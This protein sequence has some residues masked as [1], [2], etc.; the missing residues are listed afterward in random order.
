MTDR[1]QNADLH[2]KPQIFADNRRFS[3]ISVTFLA[4][5]QHADPRGF[6]VRFSLKR[7]QIHVD[8]RVVDWSAGRHVDHPCGRQISPWPARKVTEDSPLKSW[9]F[10]HLE[11]AGFSQQTAGNRRLGSVTLGAS[12]LARPEPPPS[13]P[14]VPRTF[15]PLNVNFHTNRPKRP[16]CPWDVPNLSAGRSRGTP[17]TKFLYVIFLYRL[18]CSPPWSSFPWCSVFPW[19]FLTKEIPWCFEC[20]QPFFSVFLGFV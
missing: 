18:F 7:H 20:F 17:T 15:C 4:G 13:V 11:G 10:K 6:L 16:G 14:S 19:S 1:A 12:P 5:P 8:Q 3:Q 9:K 2:R